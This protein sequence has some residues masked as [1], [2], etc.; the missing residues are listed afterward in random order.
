MGSDLIGPMLISVFLLSYPNVNDDRNLLTNS[1]KSDRY[2]VIS[3][4]F[5]QFKE[6]TEDGIIQVYK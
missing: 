3:K 1:Y 4:Q 2:Y 6:L 5:S